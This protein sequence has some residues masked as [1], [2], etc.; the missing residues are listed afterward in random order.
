MP[1]DQTSNE[2]LSHGASSARRPTRPGMA[3]ANGRE[4]YTLRATPL[5]P[6]AAHLPAS[7]A[8][9]VSRLREAGTAAAEAMDYPRKGYLRNVLQADADAELIACTWS[10]GQG[11]PL[12]GHGASQTVTR[13]LEGVVLE[14]RFLP[15]PDGRFEYE[16]VE[17]R[18]GS[19]SHAGQGVV[20]RVWGLDRCR[21]LQVTTPFNGTPTVP[22]DAA[23]WPLLDEARSR[24]LA[25]AGPSS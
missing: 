11:T 19:W 10:P 22:V 14:E 4:A 18:A 17:L 25:T 8:D 2:P 7:A 21:T 5:P 16:L 15:T 24:F 13:V 23:A 12:H 6:G 3:Q 9:G 20:H 1:S